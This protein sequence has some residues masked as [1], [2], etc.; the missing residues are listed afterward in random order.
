[1]FSKADILD[2]TDFLILEALVA[3]ARVSWTEL[4]KSLSLS[5]PAVAERV[6]KLEVRGVI[7]AYHARLSPDAID[8]ELLAFISVSLQNQKD[9]EVFLKR[10]TLNPAILECHHTT[11]DDDFLL[12]VRVSGTAELEA[13][14]TDDLK[15][16]APGIRTRTTVALSSFKEAPLRVQR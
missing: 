3:D 1:V 7:A 14:L 9:R 11:G 4:A 16:H 12:K 5:A 10:V 15:R 2:D 6:K 8:A 13:L